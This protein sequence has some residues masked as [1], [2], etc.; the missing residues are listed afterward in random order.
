MRFEHLLDPDASAQVAAIPPLELTRDNLA[1]VRAWMNSIP[2]PAPTAGVDVTE[3]RIAGG[4]GGVRVL[5]YRPSKQSSALPA[6]LHCHAGGFVVGSPETHAAANS[7]LAED[8]ECVIVSVDYRLA[9]ETPFP[10][11][12]DDCYDA[13]SW[14]HQNASDL[15]V[16]PTRIAVFGHS[17]GGGIAASLALRARDRGEVPLVFQALIY[18]MLD[19]RTG[20]AADAEP[21]P[22]A[23]KFVWTAANNR[24]GWNC[25]LEAEPG[26]ADV[27]P[28]ASPA[29]AASLEGLPPAFIAVGT[30]DL[31]AEECMEY[32]RRLI[33][34]GVPTE[35]HVYPGSTHAF[36]AFVGTRHRASV[37]DALRRALRRAFDR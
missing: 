33:R 31:F 3:H 34:G 2:A 32:A 29:R 26:G 37:E 15:A 17:A 24:F 14:L 9:P 22:Y 13:L 20:S 28:L 6:L 16:D 30:L 11:P 18:P 35:L 27:S 4:Q 8:V 19:D 1:G 7:A 12:L 10:G 36:D 5:V 23:G 21:H 25:L